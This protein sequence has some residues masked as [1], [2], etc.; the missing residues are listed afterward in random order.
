MQPLRFHA[1][2]AYRTQLAGKRGQR[3]RD[4][5]QQSRLFSRICE[6][7]EWDTGRSGEERGILT[8]L[9][10]CDAPSAGT[11]TVDLRGRE[12]ENEVGGRLFTVEQPMRAGQFRRRK[13]CLRAL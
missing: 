7:N 2:P 5:N 6:L 12:V 3:G 1:K 8:S 4:G 13:T 10:P 11:Y 9:L